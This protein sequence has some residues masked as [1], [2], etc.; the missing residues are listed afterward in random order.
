MVRQV[1]RG[2]AV[3]LPDPCRES[4]ATQL[5]RRLSATGRCTFETGHKG[6]ESEADARGQ[7]TAKEERRTRCARSG[8]SGSLLRSATTQRSRSETARFS[9]ASGRRRFGRTSC[10]GAG[11]NQDHQKNECLPDRRRGKKKRPRAERKRRK[12]MRIQKRMSRPSEMESQ[13]QP[14]ISLSVKLRS[15]IEVVIAAGCRGSYRS[16]R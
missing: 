2:L 5:I 11:N 14:A 10:G 15:A 8:S 6:L 9:I 4:V 12:C 1:R 16:R 7:P 3:K 13:L